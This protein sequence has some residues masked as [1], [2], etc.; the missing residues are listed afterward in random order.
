VKGQHTAYAGGIVSKSVRRALQ[1]S[2]FKIRLHYQ[3]RLGGWQ[4]LKRAS[5]KIVFDN[6]TAMKI[7]I[8]SAK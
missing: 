6:I 8:D 7:K 4:D 2:V 1:G 5:I 3:V